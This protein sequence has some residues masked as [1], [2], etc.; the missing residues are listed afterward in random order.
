MNTHR[1]TT[2]FLAALAVGSLTTVVAAAPAYTSGPP[3]RAGASHSMEQPA[4]TR[5][6]T[7]KVDL[8]AA[9]ADEL[10]KVPGISPEMAGS[11]VEYRDANGP[12]SRVDQLLNVRGIGKADLDRF[13]D[14]VTVW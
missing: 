9:S 4:T 2:L 10:A 3:Y 6:G 13:G 5:R 12:L 14:R 11:I 8:N 1:R 7:E